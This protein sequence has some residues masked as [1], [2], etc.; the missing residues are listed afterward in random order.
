IDAPEKPQADL[1]RAAPEEYVELDVDELEAAVELAT[2][3]ESPVVE[4]AKPGTKKKPRPPENA[5]DRVIALRL[6]PKTGDEISTESAVDAMRALG[7]Q[8]GRYNIFHQL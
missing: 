7:L 2:Q 3:G 4:H 8:H 6:V 1:R 5:V